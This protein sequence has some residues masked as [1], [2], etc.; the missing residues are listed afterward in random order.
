MGVKQGCPL[1][2]LLFS[3]AINSVIEAIDTTFGKGYIMND[4]NV[5][6]LDYADDL[7]LISENDSTL[8]L[9]IDNA[10]KVASWAGLKFRPNKCATLSIPDR[11]DLIFNINNVNLPKIL[12]SASYKYLGVPVGIE[13]D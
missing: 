9:M 8:Q 2:M 13:L 7:A 4:L 11:V 10:E 12:P 5:G 3:L 6:V 1:S